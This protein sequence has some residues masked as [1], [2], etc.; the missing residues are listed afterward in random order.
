MWKWFKNKVLVL[1][2]IVCSFAC[3]YWQNSI[4]G[5]SGYD[6]ER[7]MFI[8]SLCT[9][10]AL[11]VYTFLTYQ[12]VKETETNRKDNFLPILSIDFTSD[13]KL[14]IENLGKGLAQNINFTPEPTI[15]YPN[16]LSPNERIEIEIPGALDMLIYNDIF[17]RSCFTKIF[18]KEK[19]FEYIPP[20]N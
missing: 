10:L 12:V 7:A 17:G 4:F 9:L 16:S 15:S 6:K 5:N 8:V 1:I 20:N 3:I 18:F 2:L 13:G 11:I 19:K 14:R